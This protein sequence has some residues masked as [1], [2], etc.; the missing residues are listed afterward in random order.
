VR[1]RCFRGLVVNPACSRS[2]LTVDPK[3]L[4]GD[5]EYDLGRVLWT[6]LDEMPTASDI[7]RQF[8]TVVAAA[9]IARD[10]A[11]DWV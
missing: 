5:V 8:D 3:L 4:R 10:R 6:R 9:G 2:L 1:C 7:V 11:R